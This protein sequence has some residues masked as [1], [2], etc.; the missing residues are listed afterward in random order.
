ME[1][2]FWWLLALPLF[3]SRDLGKAAS[4]YITP[5]Y[6]SRIARNKQEGDAWDD[7][8]SITTPMVGGG[9]GL[10]F[11]FGRERDKHLAVEYNKVQWT[12]DAGYYS[13]QYGVALL[14]GL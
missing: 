10:M 14:F 11:H 5:R 1:F 13:T 9:I 2:E 7:T 8:E 6:I 12:E 4:L 3:V